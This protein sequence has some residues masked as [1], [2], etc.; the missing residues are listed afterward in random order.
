MNW[1]C[2]LKAGGWPHGLTLTQSSAV[3]LWPC[4]T[5]CNVTF[6][7]I[8]LSVNVHVCVHWVQCWTCEGYDDQVSLTNM[9]LC[10][11]NIFLCFRN[12]NVCYVFCFSCYCFFQQYVPNLIFRYIISLSFLRGTKDVSKGKSKRWNSFICM[13]NLLLAGTTAHVYVKRFLFECSLCS[14]VYFYTVLSS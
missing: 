4:C 10:H 1:I 14:V 7:T 12:T 13:V 2:A 5:C 8:E 11:L 6:V 3:A 9:L